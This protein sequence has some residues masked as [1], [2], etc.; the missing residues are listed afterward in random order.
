M[1]Y[2][3][4]FLIFTLCLSGL[5]AQAEEA[6][7][8][9][10]LW[11]SEGRVQVYITTA[12]EWKAEKRLV[13][14]YTKEEEALLRP[15]LKKVH[16]SQ[17]QES[18]YEPNGG[19]DLFEMKKKLDDLKAEGIVFD[20]GFQRFINKE[21]MNSGLSQDIVSADY[22]IYSESMLYEILLSMYDQFGELYD[23][24]TEVYLTQEQ[25]E[26]LREMFSE[27]NSEEQ[28]QLVEMAEK[29]LFSDYKSLLLA[30]TLGEFSEFILPR[31]VEKKLIEF[32]SS[33]TQQVP[34]DDLLGL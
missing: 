19:E 8:L 23:L 7:F 17:L 22:V 11:Q 12:K 25:M 4:I 15:I 32:Y 2:S 26:Q 1:V 13:D 14:R 10:A 3:R 30:Y 27:L 18:I 5:V 34:C 6:P 16:L 24:M 9:F 21:N 29:K 31:D 28:K 33:K 20:R